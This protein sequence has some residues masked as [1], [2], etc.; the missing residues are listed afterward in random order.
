MCVALFAVCSV[1]EARMCTQLRGCLMELATAVWLYIFGDVISLPV[2][3][4][5]FA[6]YSDY[7]LNVF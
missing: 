6:L 7:G 2:L 3:E 1:F 4:F 5:C